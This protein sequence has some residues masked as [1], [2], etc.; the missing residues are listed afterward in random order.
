VYEWKVKE[1]TGKAGFRLI[2][3]KKMGSEII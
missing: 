3:I 1:K 2:A